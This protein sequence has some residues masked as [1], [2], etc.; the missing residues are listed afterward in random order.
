MHTDCGQGF[1]NHN[2]CAS[3]ANFGNRPAP[4]LATV[5][6]APVDCGISQS[7]AN[8]GDSPSPATHG[9]VLLGKYGGYLIDPQ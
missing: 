4:M 1:A 5:A 8:V 2:R 3:V 6:T 9:V 7:V